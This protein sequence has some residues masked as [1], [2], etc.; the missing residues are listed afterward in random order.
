MREVV[1]PIIGFCI[2]SSYHLDGWWMDHRSGNKILSLPCMLC[3]ERW[4]SK[5]LDW[6]APVFIVKV[7]LLVIIP[8]IAGDNLTPEC[9]G[10]VG[11]R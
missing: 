1:I 9:S 7:T 6:A 10:G 8:G 11:S 2:K 5:S 4:G 3:L